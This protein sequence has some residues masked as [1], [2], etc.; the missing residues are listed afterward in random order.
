MSNNKQIVAAVGYARSGKDEFAKIAVEEFGFTRFAFADKLRECLYALNPWVLDNEGSSP[1][2]LC[3]VI[4]KFGWDN[5][6]GSPWS[7][8]IR[9][10][11]QRFGTEVGRDLLAQDIWL[12]ELDKVDA[13]RIVITDTRF[14]NELDYVKDRGARIVRINREG[15]G[16]INDHISEVAIDDYLPDEIIHNHGTLEQYQTYVRNLLER[17]VE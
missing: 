10:L 12:K 13:D 9:E 2:A 6:K 7:G 5:Y 15:Y 11:L 14:P 16:P 4:D 1:R 3:E 17:V 8:N